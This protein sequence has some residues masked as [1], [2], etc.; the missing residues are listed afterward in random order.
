MLAGGKGRARVADAGSGR[1]GRV[2]DD[3]DIV[4]AGKLGPVLDE[5]GG[6]DAIIPPADG[7]AP[8]LDRKSVV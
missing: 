4:A 1:A 5:S 7:A 8:V 2:D 3:V 6:G